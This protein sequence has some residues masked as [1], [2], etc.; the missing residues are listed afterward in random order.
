MRVGRLAST[1]LARRLGKTSL[2]EKVR[3]ACHSAS[4]VASP[5]CARG[6]CSTLR[7]PTP[8]LRAGPLATGSRR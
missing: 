1:R 4:G 8:T 5:R 6:P 7:R 2:F 3:V